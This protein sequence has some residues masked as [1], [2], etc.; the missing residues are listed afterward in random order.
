MYSTGWAKISLKKLVSWTTPRRDIEGLHFQDHIGVARLHFCGSILEWTAEGGWWLTYSPSFH[1]GYRDHQSTRIFSRTC[2]KCH[3]SVLA[4]SECLSSERR[5]HLKKYVRN[6]YIWW[7]QNDILPCLG[8]MPTS[9]VYCRPFQSLRKI[10]VAS[11]SSKVDFMISVNPL[12]NHGFW[13]VLNMGSLGITPL[14]FLQGPS[15]GW[16][17]KIP[18]KVQLLAKY[19]R[20]KLIKPIWLV[21][22]GEI[23]DPD[24]TRP[25]KLTLCELEN[26]PVEIVSFPINSMVIFHSYV[27]LPDGP[28]GC[29]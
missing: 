8:S 24:G 20:I 22:Y 1:K 11:S 2:P 7:F 25:G 12:R 6:I 28:Q 16:Y 19:P 23:L 18:R 17:L 21:K 15:L 10:L 27:S 26:C 9:H 14:Q 3:R 5:C 13:G 29:W 4:H